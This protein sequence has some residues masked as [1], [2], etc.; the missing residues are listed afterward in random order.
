MIARINLAFNLFSV[1]TFTWGF[2]ERY[3]QNI[4]KIFFLKYVGP[5][6]IVFFLQSFIRSQIGYKLDDSSRMHPYYFFWED[7]HTHPSITKF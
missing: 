1:I 2:G 5:L 4:K 3:K 7:Y 6:V